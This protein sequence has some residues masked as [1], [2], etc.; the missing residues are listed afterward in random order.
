MLVATRPQRV[1]PVELAVVFGRLSGVVVVDELHPVVLVVPVVGCLREGQR[2]P[3][4]GGR[5]QFGGHRLVVGNQV[6]YPVPDET[7]V[8]LRFALTLSQLG[9][10]GDGAGVSARVILTDGEVVALCGRDSVQRIALRRL[11]PLLAAAGDTGG[12]VPA[13]R[14]T[15][16]QPDVGVCLIGR[17]GAAGTLPGDPAGVGHRLRQVTEDGGDMRCH[18]LAGAGEAVQVVEGGRLELRQGGQSGRNRRGGAHQTSSTLVNARAASCSFA[19]YL[20]PDVE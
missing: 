14:P 9:A 7:G 15:A 6:G 17:R 18:L 2:A 10:A 11:Q 3:V 8:G 12:V 16:H 19:V 1:V 4:G 20:A 5:L 13:E